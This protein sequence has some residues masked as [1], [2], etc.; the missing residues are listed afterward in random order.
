MKVEI[1]ISPYDVTSVAKAL[2]NAY[3]AYNDIIWGIELGTYVPAKWDKIKS[4]PYEELL[5]RRCILAELVKTF[6]RLEE[7]ENGNS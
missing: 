6:E 5:K 2:N 3:V 7:V 1:D 4:L